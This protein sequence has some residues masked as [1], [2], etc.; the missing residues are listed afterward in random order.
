[1]Q[2]IPSKQIQLLNSFGL[3]TACA[4]LRLINDHEELHDYLASLPEDAR[5]NCIVAG[6]LSNT[7]LGKSIDQPLILFRDGAFLDIKRTADRITAHV[8]GSYPFD[9]FVSSLCQNNIPGLELLSGIPGT[10]GGAISQNIAAYGQQVS[11]HLLSIRAFDRKKNRLVILPASSL[12]FSYRT[13]LLKQT[14]RFSPELIILEATFTFSSNQVV[15]PVGYKDIL[16]YHLSVGRSQEDIK[17][18]RASVLSIRNRKGMVVGCENW[19]PCAGSFFLSPIVGNETA[20]KIAKGIRG[21]NFAASLSSWYKPD[22]G[23]TRLPAALVMRAAGFLNGDQ[24]GQVALSPHHI[25][26]ICIPG[27]A[28][29]GSEI[30]AVSKIIQSEVLARTGI[31]LENEVRFLGNF[32]NFDLSDFLKKITF[33]KG[34]DE[35]VWAKN[36]GMPSH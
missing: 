14:P 17:G 36:L 32:E 35:P 26:A 13:S 27:S 9:S 1:M 10:V 11:S 34:T 20:L 16:D 23:H 3:Q 15:S 4:D 22:A 19:L 6:E 28:S 30:L 2:R 18:R 31:S 5:N 33:V 25:L 24:W 8:A 21:D 7:V 29:T 12:Q